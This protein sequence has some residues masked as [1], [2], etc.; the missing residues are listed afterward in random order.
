MT[1][2]EKLACLKLRSHINLCG[3]ET[4]THTAADMTREMNLNLAMEK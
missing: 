2:M 3:M 1:V 4:Q